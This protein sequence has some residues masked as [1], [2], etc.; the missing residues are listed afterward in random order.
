MKALLVLAGAAV[1][2]G[3]LA[4]SVP[5]AR[6]RPLRARELHRVLRE[7]PTVAWVR[8]GG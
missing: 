5:S 4:L 8:R 3:G 2:I 7:R 6:P 1:V